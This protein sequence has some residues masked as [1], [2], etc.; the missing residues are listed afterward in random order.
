MEHRNRSIPQFATN[1]LATTLDATV[2][3]PSE[4]NHDILREIAEQMRRTRGDI[5]QH[6]QH[7]EGAA[8]CAA[9]LA[10]KEALNEGKSKQEVATVIQ[11]AGAN[12]CGRQAWTCSRSIFLAEA[13]VIGTRME[14][15]GTPQEAA[16]LQYMRRG[17]GASTAAGSSQRRSSSAALTTG[18]DNGTKCLK[19]RRSEVTDSSSEGKIM[20]AT[21][22][23][24]NCG[25]SSPLATRAVLSTTS[26]FSNEGE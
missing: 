3:T 1:A 22:D 11:S 19:R 24:S 17:D 18:S 25:A 6:M 4:D 8:L 23:S 7:T 14:R 12:V 2:E 5:E 20:V 9:I 15:H 10:G 16:D 13:F 26:Y 21:G